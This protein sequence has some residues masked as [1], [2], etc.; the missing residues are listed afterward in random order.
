MSQSYVPRAVRLRVAA[1]AGHRCGYCL[2]PASLVGAPLEIDHLVP[3]ALGGTNEVENLWLA[4]S[5][6]NSHKGIKLSAID[7]GSGGIVRLFDPR[8]QAWRDHFTW[9]E[10]GDRIV[11]LTD[12]GRATVLALR[13]NRAPLVHTRRAWVSVGWHPPKM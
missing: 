7:P 6:C 12:C 8:R 3:E 1:A 2:T 9:S 10:T 11:G 4:C 5:S 13:L